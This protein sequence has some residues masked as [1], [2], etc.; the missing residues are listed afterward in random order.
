MLAVTIHRIG[1]SEVDIGKKWPDGECREEPKRH[2]E[3]RC[4]VTANDRVDRS[5]EKGSPGQEE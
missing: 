2:D 1:L 3:K 5:G 4:T